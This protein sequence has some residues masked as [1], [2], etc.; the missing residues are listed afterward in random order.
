LFLFISLTLVSIILL[1]SVISLKQLVFAQSDTNQTSIDLEV[2]LLEKAY[3]P[4]VVAIIGVIATTLTV[5]W[6]NIQAHNRR[7]SFQRLIFRELEEV[8]PYLEVKKYGMKWYQHQKR[9]FI[10]QEIFKDSTQNRDFIFSLD[11]SVVYYVTQLWNT[12][13]PC[14]DDP[15]QWLHYLHKIALYSNNSKIK[16]AWVKWAKIIISYDTNGHHL[17]AEEVADNLS[18]LF[19]QWTSMFHSNITIYT[20]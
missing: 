15:Q 13:K 10:H 19:I 8:S 20:D 14:H 7:Q 18:G 6:S 4:I 3:I 1:S 16:K 5:F 17:Q 11:P 2:N 9:K 12:I